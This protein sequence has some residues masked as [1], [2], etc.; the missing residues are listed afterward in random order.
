M[1]LLGFETKDL[2][3][4]QFCFGKILGSQIANVMELKLLCLSFSDTNLGGCA[5]CVDNPFFKLI[6]QYFSD[7]SKLSNW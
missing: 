5:S 1:Q 6:P 7:A 4:I 3:F 2:H